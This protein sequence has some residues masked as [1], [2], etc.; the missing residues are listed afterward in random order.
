MRTR[1]ADARADA[2]DRLDGPA[3]PGESGGRFRAPARVPAHGRKRDGWGG[4]I[5]MGQNRIEKIAERY[6]VGLPEGFRVHAGTSFPSARRM[7]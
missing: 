1:A 6:A 4:G 5:P 2:L 3:E 7:S